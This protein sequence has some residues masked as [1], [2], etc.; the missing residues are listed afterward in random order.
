VAEGR[1]SSLVKQ[2]IRVSSLKEMVDLR[3]KLVKEERGQRENSM[4]EQ[5]RTPISRQKS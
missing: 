1:L 3:R 5:F 4:I 2:V